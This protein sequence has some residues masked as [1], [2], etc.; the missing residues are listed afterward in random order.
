VGGTARS[1]IPKYRLEDGICE[2]EFKAFELEK[3]GLFKAE[4]GRRICSEFTI[5][6]IKNLG[7][8]AVFIAAGMTE[9]I[10]MAI[11]NKPSGVFSALAFLSKMKRSQL[12]LSGVSSAVVIGGG[13]TAMD[14]A[15]SLKLY[16]VENVYIMYRRS[17]MELPAWPAEIDKVIKSGVH[18]LVLNQPI[19]YINVDGKL[20]GITVARTALGASDESGRRAPVVIENS[21]FVFPAEVCIEAVGQRISPELIKALNGVSLKDGK[22]IVD[23]NF[24]TTCRNVFAGGDIVN[25]GQTVVQAVADGRN[26]A[27]R[28]LALI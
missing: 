10:G 11:Q 5:S 20:S 15:Y 4:F 3:T 26:A 25:G 16:G 2:N 27:E 13:N 7:F 6:D 12:S 21:Q 14:T 8:S 23:E 9:D 24:M 18:L 17:F 1:V 19:G 28:I 22:I